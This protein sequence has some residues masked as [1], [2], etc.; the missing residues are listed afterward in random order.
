MY[1]IH[2][3]SNWIPAR[4]P[5]KTKL[6][7]TG[8]TITSILQMKELR[9]RKLSL[10]S[11]YLAAPGLSGGSWDL[12]CYTWDLLCS[13][14]N[15]SSLAWTRIEPGRLVLGT[16]NL[17]Q[18]TTREVLE[19]LFCSKLHKQDSASDA[20]HVF[21]F[22]VSHVNYRTMDRGLWIVQEA[23]I[24]IIPKKKKCKKTKCLSEE[25]YK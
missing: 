15:P 18:Q 1:H 17:N 13:M 12:H 10:F 14:Q 22:L 20:L 16:Q 5:T 19:S 11:F 23:V 9:S 21:K 3:F 2:S 4:S 7:E 6:Y 8:T 24:K 25:A